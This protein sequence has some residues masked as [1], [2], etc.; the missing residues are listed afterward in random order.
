MLQSSSEAGLGV[1]G[2]LEE[3]GDQ[4][5]L[6]HIPVVDALS[7]LHLRCVRDEGL[8]ILGGH[9]KADSMNVFDSPVDTLFQKLQYR[10]YIGRGISDDPHIAQR[11]AKACKNEDE[12][13]ANWVLAGS[14]QI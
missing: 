12:M 11:E 13:R 3:P 8:S 6:S 7:I 5:L 10:M 1:W 9:A 14:G 2:N 4:F